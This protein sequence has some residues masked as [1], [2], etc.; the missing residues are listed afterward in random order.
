MFTRDTTILYS[1]KRI[2]QRLQPIWQGYIDS[3][4][5]DG[6][7]NIL[8][9][10]P[11]QKNQTVI[12]KGTN[13]PTVHLICHKHTS[14]FIKNNKRGYTCLRL[15]IHIREFYCLTIDMIYLLNA[16]K[17]EDDVMIF[18]QQ[19][20]SK[21]KGEKHMDYPLQYFLFE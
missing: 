10:K 19:M 2:N 20:T 11:H 1:Y 3:H 14:S 13:I 17:L 5:F 6:V 15:F 7:K 4:I 8:S 12:S 9:A 18:P 16:Q 21:L